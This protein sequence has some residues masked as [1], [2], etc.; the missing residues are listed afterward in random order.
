MSLIFAGRNLL[1]HQL[2]MGAWFSSKKIPRPRLV[3][4]YPGRG[5][6]VYQRQVFHS[7][8]K[9]PYT[10]H[11]AHPS[12]TITGIA[13]CPVADE[14]IQTPEATVTGGGVNC[15]HVRIYLEPTEKGEWAYDLAIKAEENHETK[16]SQQVR[17]E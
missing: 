4:G 12:A 8:Q 9:R 6:T 3:E 13:C 14:N 16:P 7:S 17:I 5:K 15:K 11:F 10:F 2:K 1:R